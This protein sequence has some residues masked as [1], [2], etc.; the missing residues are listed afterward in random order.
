MSNFK[1]QHDDEEIIKQLDKIF[2][3]FEV[4][5][6]DFIKKKDKLD[7]YGKAPIS[8]ALSEPVEEMIHYICANLKNELGMECTKSSLIEKMILYVLSDPK[9]LSNFIATIYGI[10]R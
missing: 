8:I 1:V 10:A 5:Y 4:I 9:I 2:V 7:L 6:T 3:N